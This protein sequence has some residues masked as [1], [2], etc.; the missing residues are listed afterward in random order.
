MTTFL[1]RTLFILGC[2][3]AVVRPSGAQS[4]CCSLNHF[5]CISGTSA[6]P[7]PTNAAQCKARSATAVWFPSGPV[8]ANSCV[9]RFVQCQTNAQCCGTTICETGY[10]TDYKMCRDAATSCKMFNTSDYCSS[11]AACAW[12]SLASTCIPSF[13]PSIYSVATKPPS[14]PDPP[15]CCSSSQFDCLSTVFSYEACV[16][17]GPTSTWFP[18]GL[19]A[20]KE[21]CTRKWT[22]A[23]TTNAECCGNSI[24]EG[25]YANP[26]AAMSC[27]DASVACPI[28][29]TTNY[30]NSRSAC[31]WDVTSKSCKPS[32]N[33][34]FYEPGLK[35]VTKPLAKP[36]CSH[37]HLTCKRRFLTTPEDCAAYDPTFVWLPSGEGPGSNKANCVPRFNN[38]D[39]RKNEDCCGN[40][41]CS[42]EGFSKSLKCRHPA[43][44]CPTFTP[45]GSKVCGEAPGC[46]WDGLACVP[47]F[48]TR[49]YDAA[50]KATV[51]QPGTI[52][53]AVQ[54]NPDSLG[55]CTGFVGSLTGDPH[56]SSFDKRTYDCQGTGAFVI[57]KADGQLEIQGLFEKAGPGAASVTRGIAIEYPALADV[58]RIQVSIAPKADVTAPTSY[59][60]NDFCAAHIYLDGV[61]QTV[62]RNSHLSNDGSYAMLFN[63]VGGVDIQFFDTSVTPSLNSTSLRIR[64]GG[65]P[66][67]K[68]GCSMSTWIC[69]PLN[70]P[71]LRSDVVGLLGTPNGNREDDWTTPSGEVLPIVPRGPDS[72]AYCT[73]HYCVE[74][75][76]ESLFKYDSNR[77]FLE[78][79]SCASVYPGEPVLEEAPPEI[80]AIC[81]EDA[82]CLLDGINGG[83]EE[84][85]RNL[86]G[87]EVTAEIVSSPVIQPVAEF[88]I[89]IVRY[90]V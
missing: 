78:Q 70:D 38:L 89:T 6:S 60:I 47:G 48:D 41:V 68:F 74:T 87:Q 81:G 66:N 36:C 52:K 42:K 72:F 77:T 2:L 11:R 19:P 73:T 8:N 35:P 23:C 12:D 27:R 44:S 4:A 24:C 79:Y 39:C 49:V 84:A 21:T 3:L 55:L 62:S 67:D 33:T 34:T 20:N 59:M 17:R 65:S 71:T 26:D 14:K 32:F 86:E 76:A 58:P 25:T 30:C 85:I 90:L 61:L 75:A 18:E 45:L 88:N 22:N 15:S 9:K 46:K 57:V 56:F 82:A 7:A 51:R 28:F 13:D 40:M 1:S 83:P 5:Q 50:L 29:N 69:L 53:S 80:L 63:A 37:D 10:M 54:G 31:R 64:V 43:L 16:A